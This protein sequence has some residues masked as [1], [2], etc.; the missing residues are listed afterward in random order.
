MSKRKVCIE[1]MLLRAA[2]ISDRINEIR[3]SKALTEMIN[4]GKVKSKQR[5]QVEGRKQ[6]GEMSRLEE[7]T[8]L[9]RLLTV[10]LQ[11]LVH[12]GCCC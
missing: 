5:D 12:T 4:S 9:A 10:V 11:Y 7:L 1:R 8:F 6:E 2:E 3:T